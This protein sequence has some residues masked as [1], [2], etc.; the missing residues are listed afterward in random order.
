MYGTPCHAHCRG[1]AWE[2]PRRAKVCVCAFK[3]LSL[4]SAVDFIDALNVV[5]GLNQDE[6]SS[7]RD[8]TESMMQSSNDCGGHF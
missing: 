4:R 7:I 6:T 5:R 8:M 2:K 1:Y 3:L